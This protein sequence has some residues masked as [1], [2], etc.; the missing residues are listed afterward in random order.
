MGSPC[1]VHTSK[2]VCR[3][4][5]DGEALGYWR[6]RVKKNRE[7]MKSTGFTIYFPTAFLLL[8]PFP[9]HQTENQQSWKRHKLVWQNP[10][11]PVAGLI[12]GCSRYL[13]Y[14]LC[15]CG[16]LI[17][18]ES[19]STIILI[20]SNFWRF[21]WRPKKTIQKLLGAV[22]NKLRCESAHGIFLAKLQSFLFR[23]TM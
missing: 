4:P 12:T 17:E 22:D 7:Y 19:S 6:Y 11:L 18:H 3:C 21:F 20:E 13:E 23:W 1:F 14:T 2:T 8:L 10:R 15:E 9:L 16:W 5:A